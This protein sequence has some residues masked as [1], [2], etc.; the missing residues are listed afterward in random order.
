MQIRPF[1]N[2]AALLASVGLCASLVGAALDD[3]EPLVTVNGSPIV[4]RDLDLYLAVAVG[5]AAVDPDPLITPAREREGLMLRRRRRALSALIDGRL[6][7]EKAKAAYLG[8]EDAQELFDRLAE[9]E[10]NRLETLKGSRLKASQ[11]LAEL[12]LT[13]D[14]YGRFQAERILVT[15]FIEDTVY[16]R[17]VVSPKEVRRYYD[18][19][20]ERFV[21]PRRI[22]YR[23]IL[24]A[25]LDDRERTVHLETAEALLKALRAGADFAKLAEEHSADCDRY[26]GGLHQTVLP[27]DMPDWRPPAVRGLKEGE[28]SDV[29]E[30][31]ACLA[32]V[33]LEKIEPQGVL[34][35]DQAQK[36]IEKHLLRTQRAEALGEFLK[37]LQATARVQYAPAGEE[38]KPPP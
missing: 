37:S 9:D 28:L 29:M 7:L 20:R 15:K 5:E 24:L 22:V 8:G 17:V 31:G 38:L 3:E 12:G 6:L 25:P 10:M 23:Q 18:A 34:P 36:V 21:V 13:R 35:F 1:L 19:N 14:D 33:R 11:Y 16:S 32:I 2:M 27:D 4:S 26:P 30:L